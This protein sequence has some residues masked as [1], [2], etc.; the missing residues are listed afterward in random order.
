MCQNDFQLY[1]ELHKLGKFLEKESELFHYHREYPR[2]LPAAYKEI[3]YDFENPDSSASDID[4]DD[5]NDI[6]TNKVANISNIQRNTLYSEIS[7]TE[8]SNV[9]KFINT[10]SG[11][12]NDDI[13]YSETIG[14][15]S[16]QS[17]PNRNATPTSLTQSKTALTPK[18]SQQNKQTFFTP[19]NDA[20]TP[21]TTTISNINANANINIITNSLT[22]SSVGTPTPATPTDI[23]DDLDAQIS[24]Q[25]PGSNYSD[26]NSTPISPRHRSQ[27]QK[28]MAYIA[29]TPP[30][31]PKSSGKNNNNETNNI[32]SGGLSP[33]PTR[34]PKPPP[35]RAPRTP[36]TPKTPK[37]PVKPP[38]QRA[39]VSAG[40]SVGVSSIKTN[41]D[42][43][44]RSGSLATA[45]NMVAKDKERSISPSLTPVAKA[46]SQTPE[47][48]DLEVNTAPVAPI[49]VKTVP[50]PLNTGSIASR[51]AASNEV[52][53][54]ED[55]FGGKSNSN[56]MERKSNNINDNKRISVKKTAQILPK[57][58]SDTVIVQRTIDEMRTEQ[59]ANNNANSN[60]TDSK[61]KSPRRRK[62][63]D[64]NYS[65]AV[66]LTNAELSMLSFNENDDELSLNVENSNAPLQQLDAKS[67]SY[68][69]LKSNMMRRN[70]GSGRNSVSNNSTT[71][72]NKSNKTISQISRRSVGKRPKYAVP[73]SP[74]KKS[75]ANSSVGNNINNN[76][77]NN[78]NYNSSNSNLSS[79]LP[80][81]HR[82]FRESKEMNDD[83][84]NNNNNNNKRTMNPN[85]WGIYYYPRAG[86][87]LGIRPSHMRSFDTLHKLLDPNQTRNILNMNSMTVP[88]AV[89]AYTLFPKMV[90]MAQ[91][92]TDGIPP[93]QRLFSNTI[94]VG[95]GKRHL[96]QRSTGNIN[97]SAVYGTGSN[98][99]RQPKKYS[100]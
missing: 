35:P 9:L 81:Q 26:S 73:K 88:N 62:S 63:S 24:S 57:R 41:N 87:P 20:N 95:P 72:N 25:P 79:A 13:E 55:Y 83:T 98:I 45:A 54:I 67:Q 80:I 89:P 43:G 34:R 33:T 96:K 29:K 68:S 90:N 59:N 22:E 92:K 27:S 66:L 40:A 65:V 39:T 7:D 61:N 82:D 77:N 85:N 5:D 15:A 28:T 37:K 50:S 8:L 94:K 47:V 86:H 31:P 44:I 53:Q 23:P 18:S 3:L 78:N 4:D 99:A 36:K 12:S 97:L 91:L 49:H 75:A 19:N 100:S 84:T 64:D 14:S 51:V 52:N 48:R 38:Q 71:S 1:N 10:K 2:G 11:L 60:I 46:G 56:E 30:P 16:F 17:L 21:T 69:D 74:S 70:S 93:T 6:V 42:I 32:N 58:R 76:N